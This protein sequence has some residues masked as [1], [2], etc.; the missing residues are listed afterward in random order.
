M[1]E[2]ANEEGIVRT[3]KRSRSAGSTQALDRSPPLASSRTEAPA[4]GHPPDW[5]RDLQGEGNGP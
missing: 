1:V 2:Q 4:P 3:G 5:F